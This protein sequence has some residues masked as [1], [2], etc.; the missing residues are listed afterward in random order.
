MKLKELFSKAV[1]KKNNQINLSLKRKCLM[2]AGYEDIDDLLEMKLNDKVKS[3]LR[4][5]A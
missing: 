2:R 1:N 4:K 5:N 3:M